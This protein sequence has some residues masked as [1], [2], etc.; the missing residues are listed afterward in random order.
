MSSS[1][2]S[3]VLQFDSREPPPVELWKPDRISSIDMRINRGGEWFYQGS[4]IERRRMVAL[5]STILWREQESY[6]LVTPHEK[7]QITVEVAPFIAELMEVTGAF[8]SQELCFTDNT[9]NRFTADADHPLWISYPESGQP[10]PLVI[11]R[12]NLPALMSRSVYYQLADLIV[13][14]DSVPGVWSAGEFFKLDS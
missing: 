9:G 6:F 13:E 8:E 3:L 5:F 7:L 14:K 10:Q 2:E 1:L 11:V 12:R 4:K